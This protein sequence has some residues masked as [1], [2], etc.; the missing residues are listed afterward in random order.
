M[1]VSSCRLADGG[2]QLENIRKRSIR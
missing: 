1:D 2:Y